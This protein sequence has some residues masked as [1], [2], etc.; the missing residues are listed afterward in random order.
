MSDPV[1]PTITKRQLVTWLFI[2]T[3]K[4]EGDVMIALDTIADATARAVAEINFGYPDDGRFKRSDPLF[5]VLGSAFAMSPAD[6]D[7]AFTAAAKL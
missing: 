6:L 5:D 3:G 2:A 1:I 7:A 4:T